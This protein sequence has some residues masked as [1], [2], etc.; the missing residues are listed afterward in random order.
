MKTPYETM[1]LLPPTISEEEIDAFMGRLRES[2]EK[3]YGE[4]MLIEKQGV[5]KTSYAV[6]K[7]NSAY[8]ILFQYKGRGETI[9]EVERLLKNS[10]EVM[11]YLSTKITS[12]PGKPEPKKI[13]ATPAPETAEPVA[14][15]ETAE[16]VAATETAEPVAAIETPVPP[17][18]EAPLAGNG[19]QE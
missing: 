7:L 19:T 17:A 9:S 4:V 3:K 14:A 2:V 12:K 11:K 16:P 13:E 15:T 5:K 6:N 8:Y 10:D 18:Q 1:F